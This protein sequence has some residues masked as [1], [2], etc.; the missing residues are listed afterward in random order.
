MPKRLKK[1]SAAV[2]SI[3]LPEPE[4][5]SGYTGSQVAEIM[6]DRIGEFHQW[7]S[8]QTRSLCEGRRYNHET[9][10]YEIDCDGISHGGITY[11]YDVQRF[12]GLLGRFHQEVWD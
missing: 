7:M 11:V 3:I 10:E 4:C 2:G 8:G 9:K 1:S 12:L 6:G 5:S